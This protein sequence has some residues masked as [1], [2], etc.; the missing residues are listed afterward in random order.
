MEWVAGIPPR[1]GCQALEQLE[2]K[3]ATQRDFMLSPGI[4]SEGIGLGLR[5][6][7]K[8]AQETWRQ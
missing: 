1:W 3:K 5:G 6:G 7:G 2:S 8:F 4:T